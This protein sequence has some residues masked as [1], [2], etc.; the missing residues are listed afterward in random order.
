MGSF[1][2][3]VKWLV[4][5]KKCGKMW[6]LIAAMCKTTE[7]ELIVQLRLFIFTQRSCNWWLWFLPIKVY[8]LENMESKAME[9][10]KAL[11][12]VIFS[13]LLNNYISKCSLWCKFSHISLNKSNFCHMKLKLLCTKDVLILRFEWENNLSGD[14][15]AT[16]CSYLKYVKLEFQSNLRPLF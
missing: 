7:P 9:F 6:K 8:S 10:Q 16:A 14:I 13:L 12:A 11:T 3:L 15:Q 4:V 5:G 1:C 2:W